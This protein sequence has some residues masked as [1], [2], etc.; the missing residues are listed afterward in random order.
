MEYLCRTG[1]ATGKISESLYVAE[2]KGSLARELEEKGLH[3]LSIKRRS[4][5]DLSRLF[6]FERGRINAREFLVFN[7]ELA[8]LL[9]AGMPLV[10]S[11]DLLRKGVSGSAFRSVLDNVHDQ[12][13]SGVSLSD[14][15]AENEV[16]FPG[17]YVA[18]LLA[19]EKSGNLE[20]MLRRYVKHEKIISEVKR[21]TVSALV[22]P[23][24]LIGL[25]LIVVGVI[26]L[27]VVPEF[28][29]FYTSFNAELPLI[30]QLIV[31]ASSTLVDNFRVVLLLLS[32]SAFAVLMWYKR[33]IHGV[34]LDRLVL[35]IPWAGSVVKKF[36][37]SQM[38]RTLATLLSGGVP[39]VNAMDIAANAMSNRYMANHLFKAGRLVRE[40]E[41]VSRAMRECGVFPSVALKMIEVGEST[42]ALQSM[43]NSVA[44]FYDEDLET[45]LTRFV[46]LVEPVLLVLMGIIIAG[47]L[48]ALYLP[49]FQLSS[50][51]T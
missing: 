25:A 43:L 8:T 7:Q 5:V 30:T 27:R 50:V 26:V 41:G 44:D 4:G 39:L 20:V 11:L 12:V 14:A 31:R 32:G 15:F 6:L 1:T 10:H 40:G 46:T 23:G 9:E 49:L 29:N 13:E 51:L 16:V 42:G 47:L 19:G 38:S 36:T 35:N 24:I 48:L 33:L 21:R 34:V 17:A 37:T 45:N 3:V 22:Y 2:D 18:S 28:A